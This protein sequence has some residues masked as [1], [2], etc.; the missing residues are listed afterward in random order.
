MHTSYLKYDIYIYRKEMPLSIVFY[1]RLLL[2]K[3]SELFFDCIF[4][5][6]GLYNGKQKLFDTASYN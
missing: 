6:L 5:K 3:Y 2:L 1:E 4:I